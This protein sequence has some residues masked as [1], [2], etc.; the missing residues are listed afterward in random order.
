MGIKTWLASLVS[1]ATGR[2]EVGDPPPRRMDCDTPFETLLAEAS[3]FELANATFVKIQQRIE[4]GTPLSRPE[5]TVITL[6]WHSSGIIDNGGFEY[7]FSGTFEFDPEFRAAAEA[8]RTVGLDGNFEAFQQALALFP[9][10]RVPHRGDERVRLYKQADES[11]REEI[12][13]MFWNDDNR[14]AQKVAQYIREHASELGDL[15]AKVV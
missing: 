14:L 10:G 6:I 12:N 13:R 7:L 3:D 8:Y 1:M 5:E 2:R 9:D 4:S 11:V 15:D